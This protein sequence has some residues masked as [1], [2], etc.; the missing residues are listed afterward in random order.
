MRLTRDLLAR[1]WHSWY[2][3]DLRRVGP[4]WLQLLWTF[5]FSTV[6]GVCFTILGFALYARGAGA[7]RNWAGWWE[8]FVFNW[9]TALII[10][11]TIHGLF[12]L[13]GRLVGVERI[14]AF[15]LR[16][17]AVFFSGV[18]L[19]GVA[20]GWPLSVLVVGGAGP[21]W[22]RWTNPNNIAGSLLL[23]GVICFV[24]YKLFAAKSRQ[25]EAEKRATEA[26][27]RVLQAQIEPH[28]LFNTLANVQSLIDSEPATAKRMLES[29]IDYL[30]CSLTHL[31]GDDSTLGNELAMADAYLTLMR[32]RMADRLD[33]RI[34]LDDESLRQARV[35]PLLLQP[36]VENAI[37]HGLECKVDGGKVTVSARVDDSQLVLAV[38]DDGLGLSDS[39]ARRTGR[40]GNGVALANLT[41]RLASRYGADASFKLEALASGA[42]ATLRLPLQTPPA[43]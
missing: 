20:I 10:G 32:M 18:P 9:Q 19:L 30:R 12:A 38:E 1:S 6:L 43:P 15:T 16:Q 21:G 42:R 2:A 8:W 23:S 28:F 17:R 40:A 41:Q 27:L 3:S 29:F 36:L 11:F 7:W 34:A 22:A 31:R 35:P 26:Q 33:F 14:R 24:I 5:V 25:I 13:A 4:E 37:H 39:P